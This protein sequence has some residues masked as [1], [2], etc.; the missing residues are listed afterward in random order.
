MHSKLTLLF[1]FM[2]LSPSLLWVANAQAN[3]DKHEP[4]T[5]NVNEE[6]TFV[7]LA[8]ANIDN[9]A[10]YPISTII[11]AQADTV[12]SSSVTEKVDAVTS[13]PT[14]PPPVHNFS[15]NVTLISQYLYRGLTQSNGRPALQGGIDYN[16]TSGLY[17]GIWASSITWIRD[18]GGY[19]D[20]SANIELDVYGGLKRS[21]NSYPDF[22]YDVGFLRYEY[23]GHY[24]TGAIK[25]NTNEIYGALSWKWLT[26]KY[27]HSLGN[28]FGTGDAKGTNYI[29]LTAAIPVRD[30]LMLTLHAG[31][32]KFKGQANPATSSNDSLF[33]YSDYRAE[34]AKS[35]DNNWQVG[36]GASFTNAKDAGYL[37]GNINKNIGKNTGYIFVKKTF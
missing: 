30:D 4:I 3:N 23:P 1:S 36:I 31:R 19:P 37:Y 17:A 15:A 9:G 16:H 34:L 11:L 10:P 33:S 5:S 25:P 22:S 26:A 20:A 14:P 24:A 7:N 27:S 13:Q 18:S 28:T 32:Q 12:P 2:F 6:A 21:L 29:D 8:L 35:F